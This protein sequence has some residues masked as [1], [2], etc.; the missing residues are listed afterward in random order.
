MLNAVQFLSEYSGTGRKKTAYPL[1]KLLL[2][3]ILAGF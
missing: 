1:E 3:S 2:L